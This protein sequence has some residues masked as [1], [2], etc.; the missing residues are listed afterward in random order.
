MRDKK[1]V[2]EWQTGK[3]EGERWQEVQEVEEGKEKA[4]MG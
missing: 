2:D 4:G 3:Q 1:E